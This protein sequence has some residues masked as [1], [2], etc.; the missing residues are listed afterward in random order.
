MKLD[1]V[2]KSR[3]VLPMILQAAWLA[4]EDAFS[5]TVT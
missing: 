3:F 4:A 1:K 2:S 5:I